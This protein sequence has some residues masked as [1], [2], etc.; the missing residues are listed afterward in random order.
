MK[1]C[2]HKNKRYVVS[3]TWWCPDCGSLG[4][5]EFNCKRIEWVY[6]KIYKEWQKSKEKNEKR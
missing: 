4:I 1:Y 5:G 2:R 3:G 6:P